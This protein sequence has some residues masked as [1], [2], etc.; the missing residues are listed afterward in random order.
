MELSEQDVLSIAHLARLELSEAETHLYQQQL[1]Q[2]FNWI[3]QLKPVDT[4][5]IE[6]LAHPLELTQPL[7][8][9]TITESINREHN[10]STAPATEGGLY[11]VPQVIE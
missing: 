4:Q 11:L 1:N 9:D 8:P 2:I 6:P 7:R 5:S 3:N 10:Q